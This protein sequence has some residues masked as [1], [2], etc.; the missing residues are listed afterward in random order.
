VPEPLAAPHGIYGK[1]PSRGDFLRAGLPRSFTDPWDAWLAAG[2]AASRA[3]LGEHWL[4]CWMEAP[5]WRF[6]L[7]DGACG[8]AA[9]LGLWLPSVDRAGRHFPL[10][11][12]T[13]APG[14]GTDALATAGA[15]WLDAAE[16]AALDALEQIL[17]PEA[18][19]AR[20]DATP[21]PAAAPGGGDVL[22]WTAGSPFVAA[23][24]LRLPGLP[25][26]A[27]FAGMIRDDA[28]TEAGGWMAASS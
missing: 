4:A 9:V 7:P 23:T 28:P 17:Q 10:T 6:A 19:T 16:A 1:L 15:A 13:L 14:A 22:W 27:H 21:P 26:P 12:A 25:D 8:P 18:L 5:I 2:I 11:L 24:S 20:L 3:A